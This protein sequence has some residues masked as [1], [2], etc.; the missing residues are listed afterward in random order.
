MK[1]FLNQVDI[2]FV[3]LTEFFSGI[4]CL[5]GPETD[6]VKGVDIALVDINIRLDAR[7]S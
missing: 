1:Q 3:H 4:F 2:S 5:P 7:P 6:Q